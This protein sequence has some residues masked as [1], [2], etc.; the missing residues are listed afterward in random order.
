MNRILTYSGRHLD[1][2]N[3]DPAGIAIGDIAVALSRACR[4]SGQCR[5]TYSVA[6]HSVL[7]SLNV[8]AEHALEA[9][10]HDATEAWLGDVSTPLKALLPEY[11]R[12][13]K[14]LDRVVRRKFGLPEKMSGP[15]HRADRVLL[16]TE[17]RDLMP[18]DPDEWP[19]LVGVSPL[20]GTILP[21]TENSAREI[22]LERWARLT[23]GGEAAGVRIGIDGESFEK[24]KEDGREGRESRVPPG[25]DPFSTLSGYVEGEASRG[26]PEEIGKERGS[27]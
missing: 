11:V 5:K 15:V 25:P 18:E 17:K 12:I 2:R 9:L 1:F 10:L 6:Q 14:N 27:R 20:P 4:F 26:V 7:V 23:G 16:A 13:E 22:F 3:P 24:G 8:P 19:V 21:W